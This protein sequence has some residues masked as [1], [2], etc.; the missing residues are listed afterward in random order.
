GEDSRVISG[1]LKDI[2]RN[3]YIYLDQMNR[4]G[5]I[6]QKIAEKY[7]SKLQL[8]TR[9]KLHYLKILP[10]CIQLLGTTSE[11]PN[12]HTFGLHQ[13]LERYD[14][15][16]GGLFSD[17][18]LKGAPIKK[19][20]GISRFPFMPEIKRNNVFND[21]QNQKYKFPKQMIKELNDRRRKHLKYIQQFRKES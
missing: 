19:T 17:S 6:A 10:E 3:S 11:Y 9:E 14:A 4:E 13:E 12:A 21:I 5:K 18:L 1:L 20:K 15:I 8:R 7:N 16:F 2:P